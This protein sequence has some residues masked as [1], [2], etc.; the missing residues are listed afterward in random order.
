MDN[1]LRLSKCTRMSEFFELSRCGD[2]PSRYT[3]PCRDASCA[4]CSGSPRVKWN[5]DCIEGK[6]DLCPTLFSYWTVIEPS[7]E[8]KTLH[9]QGRRR[10]D[11]QKFFQTRAVQIR[12]NGGDSV[13]KAVAVKII[14]TQDC[15][16]AAEMIIRSGRC[17]M[18][19]GVSFYE[20][21]EPV[22]VDLNGNVYYK[23]R[24]DGRSGV[25]ICKLHEPQKRI[26]GTLVK[27][28]LKGGERKHFKR[29][30]VVISA[31][32]PM[33]FP[34]QTCEHLDG[35]CHN[36]RPENLINCPKW[37]NVKHAREGV[38]RAA[39]ALLNKLG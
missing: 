10:T 23:T 38:N 30:R 32:N 39:R 25:P 18:V 12:I 36:D 4:R 16:G 9:Q 15:T 24:V 33:E 14:S 17:C 19:G 5:A 2:Y 20:L 13:I 1:I 21:L 8:I 27:V 26:D 29:A 7:V 31:F 34:H 11:I 35:N 22:Y 37:I 28:I 3:T 6:C